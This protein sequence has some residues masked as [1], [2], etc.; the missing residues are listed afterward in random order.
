M[1]QVIYSAAASLD[2]YIARKDGSASWIPMGRPSTVLA[3]VHCGRQS[4][5]QHDVAQ[6]LV[7][8]CEEAR[9]PRKRFDH[10]PVKNTV[11]KAAF[12]R[13]SWLK[14]TI[15]QGGD[16]GEMLNRAL[17]TKG[18]PQGDAIFGV[19]NNLMSRAV[20]AGLLTPETVLTGRV[21]APKRPA[22][23][24]AVLLEIELARKEEEE[25]ERRGRT[26]RASSSGRR[27]G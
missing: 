13:E 12:E 18:N 15:L 10:D 25:R 5:P 6:P 24:G 3:V 7:E 14:L 26:A 21:E 22:D 9:D 11:E 17:L 1:R 2:G 19:D 4:D 20:G 16:A 23:V 8:A 27:R